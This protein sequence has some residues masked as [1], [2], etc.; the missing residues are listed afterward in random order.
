[1]LSCVARHLSATLDL[2]LSLALALALTLTL[3]LTLMLTLTL[4]LAPAPALALAFILTRCD[5]C[6]LRACCEYGSVRG[7]GEG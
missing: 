6:P 2:T 7:V 5:G 1:M 4:A 3:V